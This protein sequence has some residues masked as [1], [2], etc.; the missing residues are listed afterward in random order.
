MTDTAVYA[1]GGVV[2][3][4]VDGKLRILLIS[5]TRYRDLTLPKGK[6]D[7]GETLAETAVREI[8]EET[9]IQVALG[10]PVGVS[11]YGMPNGREKIVH[12]WA[13]EATDAAVRA[14]SFSPNKEVASVEWVSL[15]KAR[16]R[17]SYP[18]DR[19]I[20]DAF[21]AL[22]DRGVLR[23]FPIV[24][25]R[26]A[27]AKSRADWDGEDAARPLTTRGRRQAN[28]IV[29]PLL[30]FG[31]RRIWSS[32]AER[33]VRTVTPLAAALGRRI[34]RTELLS[35]DAWEVGASDA[36]TIV[37]ARVR[38]RKPVVVCSHGPVLPDIIAE[39]ALATG[40]MPGSYLG[41]SSTLE[42]A[43]FSVV[44]LSADDPGAGIVA[45]ETH[46]PKV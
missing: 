36:R 37:R 24:A 20:L 1:A 13:T 10:V 15:K 23:T 3:R 4:M 41:S 2:W 7:P 45:I 42:T 22:V 8:R 32:P 25:L 34:E 19:E 12:Y 17:L 40:T 31:V 26:H 9:G 6:V 14:S 46:D 29:G 16:E 38:A 11:R 27:K 18:V 43:A 30:A 44:H 28:A 35:Q 21:A 5:R 39:L 33:C